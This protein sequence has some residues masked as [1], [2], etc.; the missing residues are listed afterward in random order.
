[1][2]D[3]TADGEFISVRQSGALPFP[4][5]VVVVSILVAVLA[6]AGAIALLA[7]WLAMTLIPIAVGGALIAYGVLRV[8]LWWARRRSLGG[9][10]NLSVP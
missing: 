2:I 8:R 7:L 10:R 9:Q 4:T 6:G 5:K 3:M 1:V